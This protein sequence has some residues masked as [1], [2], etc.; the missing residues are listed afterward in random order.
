[1]CYFSCLEKSP[2]VSKRA[3]TS[4]VLSKPLPAF[5]LLYPYKVV[6]RFQPEHLSLELSKLSRFKV[7]SYCCWVSIYVNEKF[8]SGLHGPFGRRE[9]PGNELNR[10]P[11]F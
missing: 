3:A 10:V 11:S 7:D 5:S 4:L 9:A 6:F 2:P 1:M 8:L